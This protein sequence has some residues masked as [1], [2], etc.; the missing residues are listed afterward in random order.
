MIAV[1]RVRERGVEQLDRARHEPVER[2]VAL[3]DQQQLR[4]FGLVA[5]LEAP[6]P[7]DVRAVFLVVFPID[8]PVGMEVFPHEPLRQRGLPLHDVRRDLLRAI[9]IREVAR[10]LVRG[11]ERLRRVHVRVLAAVARH[12][13]VRCRVVRVEARRAIP[14]AVLHQIERMRD[15][16]LRLFDARHRRVRGRE[17]HEREPVAVA[18]AVARRALRAVAPFDFPVVAFVLGVPVRV[19]Q[20]AQPVARV[21]EIARVAEMAV[22]H[23]MVEDEAA[24]ADEV[25]RRAVVDAAVVAEEVVEAARRVERVRRVKAQR[26]LDVREQELRVAKARDVR[27]GG[28]RRGGRRTGAGVAEVVM[29]RVPR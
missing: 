2:A 18:R 26:V 20:K 3:E 29:I 10:R 13:P 7:E 1:P 27:R 6:R 4:P 14:E 8:R 19:A 22:R 15:E 21:S 28:G 12:G 25:A 24:T 17:Q 9:E 23:R 16:R 5:G 11:E